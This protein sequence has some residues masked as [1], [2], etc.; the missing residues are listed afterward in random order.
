MTFTHVGIHES[1][2][3]QPVPEGMGRWRGEGWGRGCVRNELGISPDPVGRQARFNQ[4]YP[5]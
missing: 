3:T 4:N 2:D 1:A 5:D